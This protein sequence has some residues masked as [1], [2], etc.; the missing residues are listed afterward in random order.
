MIPKEMSEVEIREGLIAGKMLVQ[1][2]LAGP[3]EKAIVDR[4]VEEGVATLR[5][6]GDHRIIEGIKK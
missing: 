3:N 4:L 6:L 5:Y 1:G 2:K